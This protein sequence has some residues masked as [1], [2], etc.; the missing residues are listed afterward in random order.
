MRRIVLWFSSTAAAVVLLFGYHTSTQGV[1]AVGTA[2]EPIGAS[3]ATTST[4]T[5]GV[6]P[7]TGSTSTGSTGSTGSSTEQTVTG[8]VVQTR[9]GPVQVQVT[10]SGGQITSVEVLQYPSENGKDV[11]I[12]NYAL[13]ILVDETLS[14]QSANIDMVS[15]ATYSSE[16]YLTSL[17]S[18][19][20]Q[21]GL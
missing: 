10:T 9:W 20:D 5:A 17:Q 11:E 6:G 8:D 3:L 13:P 16:G 15:G 12:N 7:D 14:A 2:Q 18:A 4:T 21:A 1:T 19:L